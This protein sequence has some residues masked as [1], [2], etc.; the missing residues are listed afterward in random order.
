M[1]EYCRVDDSWQK[2]AVVGLPIHAEWIATVHQH[3][4]KHSHVVRGRPQG[5][6][7]LRG[8]R[9]TNGTV[10]NRILTSKTLMPLPL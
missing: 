3:R 10:V 4:S 8:K 6:L 5:L 2:R 1:T 7:R 9:R